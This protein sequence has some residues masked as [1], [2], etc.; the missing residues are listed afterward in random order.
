MSVRC[1]GFWQPREGLWREAPT[2]SPASTKG[3]SV[4][5]RRVFSLK[6][7]PAARCARTKL[8]VRFQG[9]LLLPGGRLRSDSDHP[10]AKSSEFQCP[11]T[12]S[13]FSLQIEAVALIPGDPRCNRQS[14]ESPC[15]ICSP[16]LGG[17]LDFPS[18]GRADQGVCLDTSQLSRSALSG[19][20]FLQRQLT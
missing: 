12:P 2:A 1:S 7:L 5:H 6:G 8:R 17:R 13:Q 18:E 4:Q 3:Q 20:K 15:Y 9:G 14:S 19:V 16:L 11:C 10:N